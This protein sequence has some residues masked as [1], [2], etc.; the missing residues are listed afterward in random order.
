MDTLPTPEELMKS[1]FRNVITLLEVLYKRVIEQEIML[2]D[3]KIF[4]A[5][6]NQKPEEQN[7]FNPLD[8]LIQSDNEDS[9]P[10]VSDESSSTTVNRDDIADNAMGK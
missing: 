3:I 5:N 1:N 7:S 2:N 8:F 6:H 9:R 10:D 4:L